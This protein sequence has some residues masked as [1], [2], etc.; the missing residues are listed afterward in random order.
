MRE[1]ENLQ[2]LGVF[3]IDPGPS[4]STYVQATFTGDTRLLGT[5]IVINEAHA[6][7]NSMLLEK[8]VRPFGTY[9]VCEDIIF[10]GD[11]V[12]VGKS[13][14]DTCR[15]TGRFQQQL[16]SH[17]YQLEF[18]PRQA[19]KVAVCNNTRAKDPDVRQALIDRYGE[20]GTKKNPGPLYGISGH[21]WQALG[22]AVAFAMR[23]RDSLRLQKSQPTRNLDPRDGITAAPATAAERKFQQ[24]SLV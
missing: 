6:V 19:V 3:A 16:I 12:H 13:I 20:P 5:P 4:Q 18:M 23:W 2:P 1:P 8:L 22:L 9:I 24:A 15:W 21:G 7:D 14:F 11:K 17:G 10:Y